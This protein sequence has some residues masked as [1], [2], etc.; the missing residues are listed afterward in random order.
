[1]VCESPTLHLRPLHHHHLP[2]VGP[3]AR[4]HLR[5]PAN[6]ALTRLWLLRLLLHNPHSRKSVDCDTVLHR[7][8]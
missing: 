8:Q 6:D 7:S 1:M 3:V 5:Q 4:F 2:V